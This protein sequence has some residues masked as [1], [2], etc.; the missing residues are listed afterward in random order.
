[1]EDDGSLLLTIGQLASR[2]G[3]AVRTIRYWSDI[4][5]VPPEHRRFAPAR[6]HGVRLTRPTNWLSFQVIR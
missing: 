1:M 5:A 4:G 2:T 3:R 6:R